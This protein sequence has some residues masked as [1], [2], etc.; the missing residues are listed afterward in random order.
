MNI[1]QKVKNIANL[2]NEENLDAVYGFSMLLFLAGVTF[3]YFLDGSGFLIL[4][5]FAPL[6]LC[7]DFLFSDNY[8]LG[9]IS[10][11]L[12]F[13][14]L[15]LFAGIAE[16][17]KIRKFSILISI[18]LTFVLISIFLEY[19]NEFIDNYRNSKSVKLY[20]SYYFILFSLIIPPIYEILRKCFIEIK[21]Y[22][23]ILLFFVTFCLFINL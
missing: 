12:Y 22:Y 14:P 10:L 8:W 17:T 20:F 6:L 9:I 5:A 18:I 7:L 16:K 21:Y 11:G 4:I 2:S 1:V 23:F 15:L 3:G 13:Y 19:F